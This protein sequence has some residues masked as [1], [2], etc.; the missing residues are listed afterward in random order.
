VLVTVFGLVGDHSV[1]DQSLMGGTSR[2]FDVVL[3][4]LVGLGVM[5]HSIMGIAVKLS[6]YRE[7][8]VLRRFLVTP[9]RIW[10][11]FVALFTAHLILAMVQTSVILLLGILVFRGT[12]YGNLGWVFLIVLVGC[13]IFLNIGVILSAFAKSPAAASGMGNV[14]VVPMMFFSGVFFPVENFPRVLSDITRIFPLKALLDLLREVG[15]HGGRPWDE[16]WALVLLGAWLLGSS[17]C[18]VRVFKF[19]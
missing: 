8:M 4:G 15:I 14:V 18:A 3:I 7:Q 13:P 1:I 17:L 6:A 5:F 16:P 12:V 10:K 2:Y 11:F 19:R 9:L